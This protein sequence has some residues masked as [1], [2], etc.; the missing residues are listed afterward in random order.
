MILII[1]AILV[2]IVAIVLWI[3]VVKIAAKNYP[4]SQTKS[5]TPKESEE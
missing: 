2:F 3:K 5:N 4:H 1:S